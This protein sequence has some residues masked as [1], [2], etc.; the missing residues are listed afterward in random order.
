MTKRVPLTIRDLVGGFVLFL[1][2]AAPSVTASAKDQPSV[3]ELVVWTSCLKSNGV[4]PLSGYRSKQ[5]LEVAF[6]ICAAQENSL[7]QAI[8]RDPS[9]FP[10]Y[11]VDNMKTLL[12]AQQEEPKR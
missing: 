11:N 8:S 3:N 9:H 2:A 5:G 12:R 10:E 4:D 7:R 1:I 6:T